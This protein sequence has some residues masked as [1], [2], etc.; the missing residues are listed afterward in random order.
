[1]RR[2]NPGLSSR[3]SINKWLQGQVNAMIEE[4]AAE[5]TVDLETAREMLHQTIREVY[6]EP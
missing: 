6:A 2:I 3:E 1:M 4:M 5:D